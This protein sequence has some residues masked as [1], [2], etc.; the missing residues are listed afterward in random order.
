M[1]KVAVLVA[2]GV[3]EDGAREV[4]GFG[5]AP[6]ENEA[7]W[8][9]FLQDLRKRGLSGVRLDPYVPL[10]SAWLA[11]STNLFGRRRGFSFPERAYFPAIEVNSIGPGGP[12]PRAEARRR[13]SS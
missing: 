13:T 3:R 7:Y 5:V 8:E 4:L 9:D 12:R 6:V 10:L 1:Q 11:L 2:L